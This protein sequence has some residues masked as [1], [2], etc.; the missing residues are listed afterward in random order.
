MTPLVVVSDFD[1]TIT[2]KDLVVA[3]TTWAHPPN[4]ALV[5][6][7]NRQEVGLKEG[8]DRLFAQLPSHRKEE[9]RHFLAR[10]AMLRPGFSRALA[11]MKFHNVP[12]YVAS[13]G[14]DFIVE[15]LLDGLVPLDHIFS[16]QAVF[17]RSFITINWARPC[18]PPC[19]GGCGLCK[20]SVIE[21]LRRKHQAPVV[22]VGDGV[23]DWPASAHADYVIARSR[24]AD[25]LTRDGR[26]Y[27][28]FD[29]FDDVIQIIAGLFPVTGKG[30]AFSVRGAK[31]PKAP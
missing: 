12:F 24:L 28:P 25:L 20:T 18:Q 11:W 27:Q 1:G 21:D 31:G 14:L 6:A 10:T 17:S 8:L 15:P 16:N 5:E 9:Y 30:Q 4:Q 29:S 26:P 7:I 13:N 3:L 2:Q 19:V 23:T 22:L